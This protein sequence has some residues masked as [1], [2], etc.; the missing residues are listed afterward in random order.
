MSKL[1]RVMRA[2]CCMFVALV[3][4]SL[5]IG[6][7]ACAKNDEEQVTA[8]A[9]EVLEAFKNP[10]QENLK[11]YFE[12][13]GVDMSV[14]ENNGIDVYEFASHA[15]ENFDY[16]LGEVKVDGGKATVEVTVK[17]ASLE[18]AMEAATADL[19]ST[20][21]Q[22]ADVIVGENGEQEFM[23]ILFNKIYEKL[24]DDPQMV[25]TPVTMTYTKMDDAWHADDASIDQLIEAMFG[26]FSA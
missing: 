5:T 4:A 9:T 12:G 14:F 6:L 8:D 16:S 26:G 7:S 10:T 20:I 2:I 21:D 13:S 15:F 25:E 24:N 11:P 19:E 1:N 17:N 3:A 22:Y 23:G 18:A